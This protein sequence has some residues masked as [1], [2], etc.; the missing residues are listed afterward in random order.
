[1]TIGQAYLIYCAIVANAPD[2][3]SIVIRILG[4]DHH[5]HHRTWSHS[6]FGS[7]FFVPLLSFGLF[8]LVYPFISLNHALFITFACF[9]SHLVTD[10][11][12]SYGICLFWTPWNSSPLYSLGVITIFD[13]VTLIIWY[14]AFMASWYRL[15]SP[16][17]ILAIFTI[18]VSIWLAIKRVWLYIAHRHS[19]TLSKGPLQNAWLQPSGYSPSLFGYWQWRGED[20]RHVADIKASKVQRPP[21]TLGKLIMEA[22][23][24]PN[25]R[26]TRVAPRAALTDGNPPGSAYRK[27]MRRHTIPSLLLVAAHAIW[28]IYVNMTTTQ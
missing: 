22:F 3:D 15:Q 18:V 27:W 26:Y 4:L 20:I 9:Y 23:L 13:L 8:S 7:L 14:A 12:T 6:V 2:I 11:I 21:L 24:G 16:T 25:L 5:K 10:W 17:I 28:F 19:W 1:L